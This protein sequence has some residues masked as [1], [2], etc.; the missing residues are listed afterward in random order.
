MTEESTIASNQKGKDWNLSS[1]AP[2]RAV[3]AMVVA[4]MA[5]PLGVSLLLSI[6]LPSL[7]R[8]VFS[9]T[10]CVF[11]KCLTISGTAIKVNHITKDAVYGK[12]LAFEGSPTIAKDM[13]SPAVMQNAKTKF[14]NLSLVS[15]FW[16][17]VLSLRWLK[18][19]GKL[20]EF[21]MGKYR[22]YW[23]RIHNYII[24]KIQH[25]PKQIIALI[26]IFMANNSGAVALENANPESDLG[27]ITGDVKSVIRAAE[28]KHDI[29]EGLLLAI[30]EI[31]S[32]TSPYAINMSGKSHFAGSLNEAK[33]LVQTAL[34]SG[35]TNI[36]IGVMQLNY[37]WHS[38]QFTSVDEM[39]TPEKNIEYAASLLAGLK[40]THGSWQEAVRYYHSAKPEHNT[41]Y[42]RK[43]VMAW[44]GN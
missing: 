2:V 28:E 39:L 22:N 10:N 20:A 18:S 8:K 11:E 29:P 30:A 14:Q 36:D 32:S 38:K 13:V 4:I 24:P 1:K 17:V 33:K 37:R 21:F 34:D 15:H 7:F 27:V 16:R 3:R 23:F 9:F 6:S 41:R 25:I 26:L 43:V 12:S 35:L 40:N 44:L 31:E 42:S 19:L 5:S